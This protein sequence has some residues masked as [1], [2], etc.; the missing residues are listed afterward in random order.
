MLKS[1]SLVVVAL[2]VAL[3][4][5]AD[6]RA[7]ATTASGGGTQTGT[8]GTGTSGRPTTAKTRNKAR[9][10][11]QKRKARRAGA[12]VG[13]DA[14]RQG[15]G[16]ESDRDDA[17]DPMEKAPRPY[18]ALFGG[19]AVERVPSSGLKITGSVFGVWDQNLLAEITSP[20]TTSALTVS[21]AYTNLIGDM[22]YVRRTTRAQ[23]AL[24]GGANARYYTGL[25]KFAANDYHGGFGVSVQPGRLTTLSANQTVS[26][27]PVFLFGLF[28][29]VLPPALGSSQTP[30]TAYAVND[31]RAFNSDS[32]VELERRFTPRSLLRAAGSLR[33]SHYT[34]V[35][36]RGTDF[37][38][39]D[40]GGDYRYRITEDSDFRL[41]YSY[42][43]ANYLGTERFGLRPQQPVE[44]NIHLGVAFHPSLTEERRTIIRFEGGS[45]LV[46]SPTATNVFVTRRQLRLVGDAAIAHQIGETWLL[47]GAF[48]RGTG[49]VQG[50]SA[51]VFTDSY[52]VTTSGF[53]GRRTDLLMSA[54]YS[55]GEPS[56][57]GSIQTFSTTTANARLRIALAPKLAFT[58]EYVFYHYDFSKVLALSTG[59]DTRVKRSVLRFGIDM[60]LPVKH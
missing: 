49:F 48:K 2:C 55:N 54:G 1:A 29:D 16:R 14:G 20:N 35:T 51:P 40:A 7:Q 5:P 42:R 24:S 44:H 46:N 53:L 13:D 30:G 38:T 57:V 31:D 17:A 58:S 6:L 50:L 21:G 9:T 41:G 19:A 10:A 39:I 8:S 43:E 52:S 12:P 22:N 3:A 59:L 32:S 45:S 37:T 34:V 11:R 60:F 33:R 23:V 28:T 4:A 36:P 47:V 56:L 18:R 25:Q 15:N 26:Y 27:A